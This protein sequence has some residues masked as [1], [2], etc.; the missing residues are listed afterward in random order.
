MPVPVPVPMP[1]PMPRDSNFLVP[2]ATFLA[3][4]VAI[5]P[6]LIVGA[7]LIA[8]LIWLLS[9]RRRTTR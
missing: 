7:L 9:S 1:M 4:C 5:L 3:V 2:N 6:L 8:G